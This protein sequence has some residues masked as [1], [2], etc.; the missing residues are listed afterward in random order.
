VREDKGEDEEHHH[1]AVNLSTIH[2]AKGLEFTAVFVV[3]CEET[4]F[5][6]WRSMESAR[7]LEEERRLMYVSVTRS[8]RYLFLSYADWRKG[9]YNMRSRFIDEIEEMTCKSR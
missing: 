4:L 2:A 1:R 8:E 3:G 7:E 6:H 5:P 9:Q